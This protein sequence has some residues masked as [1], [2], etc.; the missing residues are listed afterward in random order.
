MAIFYSDLLHT[1]FLQYFNQRQ[2]T[3]KKN[4]AIFEHVS[5]YRYRVESKTMA[6]T[7]T[8]RSALSVFLGR[9]VLYYFLFQT[10]QVMSDIVVASSQGCC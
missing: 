6:F 9:R 7:F 4:Q 8:G 3:I 1:K 10:K 5:T 2:P